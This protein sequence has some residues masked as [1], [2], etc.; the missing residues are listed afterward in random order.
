MVNKRTAPTDESTSSTPFVL[1]MAEV[2]ATGHGAGDY[3]DE[4]TLED[5]HGRAAFAP[6]PLGDDTGHTDVKRETTDED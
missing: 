6:A 5:F 2:S 1:R 4:L 3:R